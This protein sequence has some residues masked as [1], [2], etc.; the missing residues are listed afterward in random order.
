MQNC[1]MNLN[2]S[3]SQSESRVSLFNSTILMRSYVTPSTRHRAFKPVLSMF[4]INV[5]T[6]LPII[7]FTEIHSTFS[8]MCQSLFI[9]TQCNRIIFFTRRGHFSISVDKLVTSIGPVY[10]LKSSRCLLTKSS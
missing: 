5:F 1:W 9:T 4:L 2:H 7:A 3:L 10:V 8:L 6:Y